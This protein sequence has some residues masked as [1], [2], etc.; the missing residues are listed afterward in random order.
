MWILEQKIGQVD[1]EK[2]MFKD[3]KTLYVYIDQW[4][5]QKTLGDKISIVTKRICYFDHIL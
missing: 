3:Y 4:Q 2:K 1:S 5:G